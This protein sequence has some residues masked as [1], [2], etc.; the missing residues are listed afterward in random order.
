[1]V[2]VDDYNEV[3]DCIYKGEL[4]SVRDNGAVMRHQR[5]GMRA[6]KVDN[7]W[8]FGKPNEKTGYM[9][10]AG[11]RVHRIVACA[12][13]GN[14]PTEQHVVDH[15]DTNRRN[16]RPENLRWLTR[17]ENILLNDITRKK[18][19]YYCGSVESFLED[20]SQLIG[21]ED[22]DKNLGWMRT[23]SQEEA[24][25]T[26][27]NWKSLIERPKVIHES[28]NPISD[29]I[30]GKSMQSP[31]LDLQSEES[32]TTIQE[33][34]SEFSKQTD[35]IQQQ[36]QDKRRQEA[37]EQNK[38]KSERIHTLKEFIISLAN[39]HGWSVEKNVTGNGWKADIV[40]N[41][42]NSRVG[43]MLF[44]TT[45]KLKETESAMR[46]EGVK[47]YWLG[48]EQYNI[49]NRDLMPC[50]DVKISPSSI[51]VELSKDKMVSLD[52]FLFA[53]MSNRLLK[54]NFITVKKVKVRFISTQCYWCEAK[55]YLF[56]VNGVICDEFPSLV[57]DV[58]NSQ[59]PINVFQPEI[60]KGVKSFLIEN[61][62]LN[63][64]MGVIK[65]RFSRTR[66]EKYLSFGCPQCDGL[67]GDYYLNEVLLDYMYEKDDEHVH[68]IDLEEPGFKLEYIHWVIVK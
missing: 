1:M 35:E 8:T 43:L 55:H 31:S 32:Y 37:A 63:Y 3:R 14:P 25:N 44:K 12:F 27:R 18:I 39:N 45:R 64:P 54:E 49:I 52:T 59:I 23:V 5:E 22:V 57:L 28:N 21:L 6:R 58:L 36:K 60:V 7:A 53:M 26:L 65:E 56:M 46:A 51:D 24:E 11:E 38:E 29:W 4:Y 67:V 34:V 10:I 61:P 17:L 40:L 30:F 19:E 15:I 2:S 66:N 41:G 47:A 9:E 16:N 13:H 50:F 42:S 68:I 33:D 20:P 62:N 48:C